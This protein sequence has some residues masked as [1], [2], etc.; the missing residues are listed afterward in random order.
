VGVMIEVPAA[1]LRA[2]H[3]LAEVDFG[4]IGTNDLAQYTLAADRDLG[5]LA[6]LLDPWQPALLDLIATACKGARSAGRPIGVCGEAAGD[7]LL[8]LVLTGLGATSL[9]MAP[10]KVAA[11]RHALALHDVATCARMAAV[12]RSAVVPEQGREAVAA[13]ASPDLLALL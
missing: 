1:A 9:S 13:L 10:P 8:A 2:R 4:S 7:P 6:G 3:V 12:A 11:V 5:E